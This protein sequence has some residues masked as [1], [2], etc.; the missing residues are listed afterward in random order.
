MKKLLIAIIAL[1]ASCNQPAPQFTYSY[2]CYIY[3]VDINTWDTNLV[4]SIPYYN[5][6]LTA[7]QMADSLDT[8]NPY[9]FVIC[10]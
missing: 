6:T 8:P 7:Q 5:M 9:N 1:A 2:T 3:S 10:Q 4:W